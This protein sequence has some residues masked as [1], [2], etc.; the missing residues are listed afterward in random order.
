MKGI[1]L[2]A[3]AG[4][5]GSLYAAD[6]PPI[7]NH[8]PQADNG[9]LNW[10]DVTIPFGTCGKKNRGAFVEV[11]KRQT[12]VNI[13]GALSAELPTLKFNY[14]ATPFEVENTGHVVE[15][16]YEAGSFLVIDNGS[17]AERF[18]V[19][20]FHFHAPSE[21][22]VNGK[23]FDME[24]HIVHRNAW[25]DLAVVGVLLRKGGNPS[26]LIDRIM[27]NAPLTEGANEVEHEDLNVLRLLPQK[28]GYY[29]YSGSLTTPPCSEGVHWIVLVEPVN[30]SQFALNTLHNIV[31]Q[32][33]DYGGYPNN[34]RPVLPVNGRTIF[35]S[36]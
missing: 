11:G 33:H 2:F 7:W 30:I 19:V 31:S 25:G 26:D 13:T 15:V 10:G 23:Q 22:T 6:E 27:T 17:L 32:F 20:Q 34:N 21:H 18:E 5:F 8:N 35:K 3:I 24:L 1:L 14:K 4:L 12:P 36:K 9:P 29:T 28:R 16:P